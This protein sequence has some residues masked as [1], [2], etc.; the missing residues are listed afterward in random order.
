M[1]IQLPYSTP[2]P[3]GD[4]GIRL[5]RTYYPENMNVSYIEAMNKENKDPNIK[6][7]KPDEFMSL[8]SF[9]YMKRFAKSMTI[10]KWVSDA[11]LHVDN[12]TIQTGAAYIPWIRYTG[13]VFEMLNTYKLHISESML[14]M[15]WWL[16]D[17]N[18]LENWLGDEEY[19][20]II[21]YVLM[22]RT[23]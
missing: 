20:K 16:K 22:D 10:Y 8:E 23:K 14:P 4:Y 1:S 9:V 13:S 15:H 21:T 6:I 7:Y 2:S 18:A 5:P 19:S 12:E 17:L 3:C 11:I